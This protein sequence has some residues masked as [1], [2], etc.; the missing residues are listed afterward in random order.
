MRLRIS[1]RCCPP[2][3]CFGQ[4]VRQWRADSSTAGATGHNAQHVFRLPLSAGIP[5]LQWMRKKLRLVFAFARA[6]A[7]EVFFHEYRQLPALQR[8]SAGYGHFFRA[9]PVPCR[10]LRDL[11][12]KSIGRVTRA[13]LT[14]QGRGLDGVFEPGAIGEA[15][16]RADATVVPQ[17]IDFPACESEANGVVLDAKL[18]EKSSR[19]DQGI[20][21]AGLPANANGILPRP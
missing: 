13:W 11:Y 3:T 8:L 10:G 2:R 9:R 1:G 15:N 17:R 7:S 18:Q 4:A 5:V 12:D 21:L 14:S 6:E 16:C 20:S 19:F